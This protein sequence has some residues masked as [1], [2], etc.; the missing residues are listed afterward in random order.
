MENN[1]NEQPSGLTLDLQAQEALQSSAKWTLFL[2][3]LGFIGIG[4]MILAGILMSVVSSSAPTGLEGNPVFGQMRGY[5]AIFYIIFAALYF[6]PTYYLYQYS[7]GIKNGI[8]SQ[9]SFSISE[10]FV[11]LKSHHKFLGISIIVIFSLYIV[12]IVGMVAMFAIH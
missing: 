2:A 6:P 8:L 10:A 11:A 7:T 1:F 9:D 5:I 4:F 3:I 12:M